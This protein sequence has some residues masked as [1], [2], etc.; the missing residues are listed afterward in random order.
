[1]AINNS[2]S[3]TTGMDGTIISEE[4]CLKIPPKITSRG[5]TAMLLEND[6]RKSVMDY[7]VPRL[8]LGC[9]LCSHSINSWSDQEI[10]T[11]NVHLPGNYFGSRDGRSLRLRFLYILKWGE[12]GPQLD[13][14]VRE[15][16]CMNRFP[17]CG[18]AGDILLALS[19]ALI[20]DIVTLALTMF[21]I[22]MKTWLE[23]GTKSVLIDIGLALLFVLFVAF[24]L[25]PGMKWSELVR[26]HVLYGPFII[27]LAV[28]D[29]PPL[30]SA[31]VEKLEPIVLGLF[32]P[33][34]AATCGLRFEP[35]YLKNTNEF[36]YHQAIAAVVALV[37]KFGVS[38]VL[39][40]LCKMPQ[41]DSMTLA[42]I[43][44]SKGI[45]EMGSYSI[46]NDTRYIKG[47]IRSHDERASC[48][49]SQL[50][51]GWALEM[52]F[53]LDVSG[54][55]VDYSQGRIST[56]ELSFRWMMLVCTIPFAVKLSLKLD[57]LR[58]EVEIQ[59]SLRCE[60]ELVLSRV[61]YPSLSFAEKLKLALK[62]GSCLLTTSGPFVVKLNLR[63]LESNILRC[64]VEIGSEIGKLFIDNQR[65]LRC[66][67]E[68]ALSGVQY[69]SLP[70]SF[71]VK[72]KLAL[73]LRSYL[74]T[75]SGPF[76]VKLNLRCL[77][78]NIIRCEVEIGSEIGKLFIDNQRSLRREVELAFGPFVV[79]LNLRCLESNILRCEVEI[80]SEIGKLFIDNQRS[81]HREVELVLSGVQYPMLTI[82][83]VVDLKSWMFGF[84]LDILHC[85]VEIYSQANCAFESS[86][87]RLEVET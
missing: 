74:L 73:K 65:S 86:I 53:D 2:S 38:F 1:M 15:E 85:E 68:L 31:L 37:I 42:F 46:M 3:Y 23:Q 49:L 75:T 80:G 18:G 9:R 78:S 25:R 87:L 32:L 61:Q 51:F 64:E 48:Q 63:C 43:M 39:P 11:V 76:V 54:S 41:R 33:V 19:A 12:D 36:A 69:P 13:V 56:L 50:S 67:V 17:H 14:Q 29:G 66:E 77:E 60:V 40:L 21:S 6:R 58:R 20:G 7:S 47:Y 79:K 72:L 70:I 27:G 26:L 57:I 84:E 34:F 62:L 52:G 45:V 5:F 24:V 81:L 16:G 71:A 30:G 44:T 35:S 55:G 83:S 82:S 4:V 22:M 28:L 10:G 8:H 59:R